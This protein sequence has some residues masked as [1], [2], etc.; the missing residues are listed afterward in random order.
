MP[1]GRVLPRKAWSFEGPSVSVKR[2]KLTIDELEPGMFV[3]KLDRPWLETPFLFQGFH[4][5][6]QDDIR[7]LREHCQHV[8]VNV[9]RADDAIDETHSM[10]ALNGD[11]EKQ[12]SGTMSSVIRL[13]TKSDSQESK[14][15]QTN[16]KSTEVNSTVQMKRELDNA[17]VAYLGASAAIEKVMKNI[18]TGADVDLADVQQAIDPMIESVQRNQD[19]LAWLARIRK[20]DVYIFDH[21]LVASIWLIIFGKHLNFDK[22][23]LQTVGMGGLF[24]DVGKTKIPSQI[25]RKTTPLSDKEM[26]LMRKHVD[27]GVEIVENIGGIDQRVIEMIATHHERHN[28][29]GYPQ[30]LE[31]NQIPIFGRIAGIV[32]SYC[33]MTMDR[34]YAKAVSANDAMMQLNRLA[35]VEFQA[36]MVEQF[37]QSIG[38]FP[39]GALVELNSGEV[40]VVIAQNRVQRLRPK[41]M[42]LLDNDKIPLERFPEVDLRNQ[43]VD[44][45]SDESLWIEKGLPPGAYGIDPADYYL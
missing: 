11:T 25:L 38:T 5:E 7:R 35:G 18:E 31:G 12:K 42:I 9:D 29:T 45:T 4:I 44:K 30:G 43:L 40:G 14:S 36:D 17:N 24:L 13:P 33:A 6:S 3:A 22:D 37:V 26:G 27:A 39:V 41:I 23:M 2:E 16:G 20:K 28:G 15:K 19:A 21:S 10:P 1:I 32:D 8:F 34:P